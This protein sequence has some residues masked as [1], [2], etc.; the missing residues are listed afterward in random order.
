MKYAKLSSEQK[1]EINLSDKTVLVVDDEDTFRSL[2]K[3][4]LEQELK[5][6]VVETANP[7]EAFEYLKSSDKLPD[8]ILMDMQMPYM[9]GKTAIL[10]LKNDKNFRHIPVI[11][12]T[13]LA[14][15]ILVESLGKIGI[16]GY[17][18]KPGTRLSITSKVYDA[19]IGR[20]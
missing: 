16:E 13:A 12:F 17:I 3:I 20:D 1:K 11:A 6:K 18:V 14:D 15:K 19:I 2:L 8:T 10:H 9:D 4:I 7:K 5:L